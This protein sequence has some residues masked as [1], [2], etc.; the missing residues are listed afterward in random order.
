MVYPSIAIAAA[1]LHNASIAF[2]VTAGALAWL[3]LVDAA[4]PD[5]PVVLDVDVPVCNGFGLVAIEVNMLEPESTTP[6]LLVVGSGMGMSVPVIIIGIYVISVLVYV[7][8]LAPGW[9]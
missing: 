5:A 2:L 6:E 1:T 8:V 7:T 3:L 4:I 9:A